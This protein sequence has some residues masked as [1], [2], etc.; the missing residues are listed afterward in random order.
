MEADEE[1]IEKTKVEEIV[2]KAV[3]FLD[4]PEISHQPI[5]KFKR[6]ELDMP[7]TIEEYD[8]LRKLLI[9]NFNSYISTETNVPLDYLSL[10][11]VDSEKFAAYVET[12]FKKSTTF[13]NLI[14]DFQKQVN[15]LILCKV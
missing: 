1:I 4:L 6:L 13:A 3:E 10:T 7:I 11:Q 15:F 5:S 14:A 12:A 2:D 9:D 8:V